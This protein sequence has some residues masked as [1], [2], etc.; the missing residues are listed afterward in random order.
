M[1]LLLLNP[2]PDY[3]EL[4]SSA[5]VVPTGR[6][7]GSRPAGV[8]PWLGSA[9]TDGPLGWRCQWSWIKFLYNKGSELQGHLLAP[10]DPW[11]LVQEPGRSNPLAPGSN[12]AAAAAGP[13]L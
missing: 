6:N 2:S 12:P 7:P 8:E 4:L 13:V 1:V 9:V 3:K 11:V 5:A 10:P